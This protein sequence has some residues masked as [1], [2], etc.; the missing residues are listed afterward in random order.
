MT[1]GLD[2]TLPERERVI[3]QVQVAVLPIVEIVP[4]I[5]DGVLGLALQDDVC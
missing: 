5:N 3:P 1:I 2:Q 4:V